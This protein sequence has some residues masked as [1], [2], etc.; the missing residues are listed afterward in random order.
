[1]SARAAVPPPVARPKMRLVNFKPMTKGALRGF[2]SIELPSG[3]LIEDC[4]VLVSSGK[5]WASLPSRPV[6]DRQGRHVK[7]DGK[8]QYVSILKWRDRD[9]ADRWSAAVVE[10]VRQQ[11]PDVFGGLAA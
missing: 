6:L 4:P 1:M 7:P 10:L 11:H 5:A 2:A 8:P 9:L 3:L